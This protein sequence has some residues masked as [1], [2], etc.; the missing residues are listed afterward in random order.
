MLAGQYALEQT[1][2]VAP[3]AMVAP[4]H[5]PLRVLEGIAGTALV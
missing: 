2:L 4:E 5:S 3:E 1:L